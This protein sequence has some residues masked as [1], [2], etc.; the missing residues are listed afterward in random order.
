[1]EQTL[2]L[3]EG[4]FRRTYES[5]KS[6]VAKAFKWGKSHVVD[7]TA[8]LVASHPIYTAFE[9]NAGKIFG[10]IPFIGE[11]T[12]DLTDD[13][14]IGVRKMISLWSYCGLTIAFMAASNFSRKKCRITD[15]SSELAQTTHDTIFPV[16][17]NAACGPA[18]YYFGSPAADRSLEN[19]VSGTLVAMVMG[20]VTGGIMRYSVGAARDLT[21]IEPYKRK[22]YPDFIRNQSPAAKRRIATLAMGASLGLM[23]LIYSLTDD[24]PNQQPTEPTPVIIQTT[25]SPLSK[26]HETRKII[27]NGEFYE[28]S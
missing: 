7:T 28:S 23:G 25:E 2:E 22:T 4:H 12:K 20:A 15:E 5:I 6:P 18:L 21:E 8:L 1:M 17:F 24:T 13:V 16:V 27:K 3:R 11:Y 9:V 14:S 19:V 10:R 26:H